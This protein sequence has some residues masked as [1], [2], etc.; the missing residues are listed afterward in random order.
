[1]LDLEDYG[2]MVM[3][4]RAAIGYFPRVL[5]DPEDVLKLTNEITRL[6]KKVESYEA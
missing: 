5:I 6:K 2:E 4:A 1:M 3:M